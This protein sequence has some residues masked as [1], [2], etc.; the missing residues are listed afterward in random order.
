MYHLVQYSRT[1]AYTVLFIFNIASFLREVILQGV[2]FSKNLL[3]LAPGPRMARLDLNP[4]RSRDLTRKPF[5]A[6]ARCLET[7]YSSALFSILDLQVFCPNHRLFLIVFRWFEHLPPCLR[8]HRP[9]PRDLFWQK[10]I[11]PGKN[12]TH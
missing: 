1:A 9:F 10:H 4:K 12:V 8:Y 6:L 3:L 7:N 11:C 5:S 2:N